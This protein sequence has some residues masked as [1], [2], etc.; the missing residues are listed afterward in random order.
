MKEKILQQ[1]KAYTQKVEAL[2]QQYSSSPDDLLNQTPGDGGWSALQTMYH[3]V[4]VEE[5][6]LGYVRKKMSFENTFPKAGMAE[7]WHSFQLWIFLVAPFKF[8]A[9]PRVGGT[10]EDI[11]SH[12]TLIAIQERWNQI[13]TEW[14]TFFEQLTPETAISAVYRHPRVGKLGWTHTLAFFETHF[15]RHLVQIKNALKS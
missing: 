10:T 12:L 11:P 4:L 9:P 15:D 13:R 6:S 1:N 5:L 3:L 8:K 14:T 2:L 7:A